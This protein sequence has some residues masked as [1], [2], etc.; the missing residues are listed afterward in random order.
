MRLHVPLGV[1]ARRGEG[2]RRD[3][4]CGRHVCLEITGSL[5]AHKA[6]LALPNTDFVDSWAAK[7]AASGHKAALSALRGLDVLTEV[8]APGGPGGGGGPDAG[9]AAALAARAAARQQRGGVGAVALWCLH[10][11]FRAQL[12]TVVCSG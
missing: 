8:A 3:H 7:G 11:D 6:Y 4:A 2:E 9:A 12:Q 1:C 10:P 5:N